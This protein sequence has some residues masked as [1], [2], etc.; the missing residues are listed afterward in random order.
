MLSFRREQLVPHRIEGGD[1]LPEVV[2]VE[3]LVLED[4]ELPPSLPNAP[5]D[6]VQLG[7]DRAE[8]LEEPGGSGAVPGHGVGT[9]GAPES[10]REP[11]DAFSALG[12]DAV[13]RTRSRETRVKIDGLGPTATSLTAGCSPTRSNY[14]KGNHHDHTSSVPEEL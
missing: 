4:D 7:L 14:T 13:G 6:S 12:D 3:D 9:P 2:L 5:R 11:L 10:I 8:P 1:G